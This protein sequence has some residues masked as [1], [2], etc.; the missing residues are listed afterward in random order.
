MAADWIK[1][2][3][4]LFT[5]PKV[6]RISSALKADNLRTVGGLMSV[7][8]L[9]D[10]HS[11]DGRIE[12]YTPE[13]LDDMLRW[14]GFAEQMIAVEWLE[15]DGEALVL[16]RFDS[17]NGTSAKRRA[18]DA[19][20]KKAVRKTSASQAD[21]M[22]TREEKRREEKKKE[23]KG[24]LDG[25][26]SIPDVDP[27]VVADFLKI[28]KAKRAPLTETALAG[29]QREATKAGVTLEQAL[30]TCCERGWSGFK[31]DW[32]GAQAAAT[33]A[34]LPGGGRREL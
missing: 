21:K 33:K 25:A 29:I 4:D 10:A 19:S 17:H 27:N 2:R 15:Q 28:R 13:T 7:W 9:F 3:V 32:V 31:A 18:Q 5:H 22:R 16:P 11:V 1:M 20:R 24:A 12:G 6:V 34:Q 14:P 30:R 23:E 8:C 26:V